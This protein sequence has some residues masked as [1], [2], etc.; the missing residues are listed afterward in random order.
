MLSDLIRIAAM[1]G[2]QKG[3]DYVRERGTT[4]GITAEQLEAME[5]AVLAEMRRAGYLD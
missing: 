1:R 3:M 4:A 5:N 2:A